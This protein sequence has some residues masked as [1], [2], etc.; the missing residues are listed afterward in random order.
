MGELISGISRKKSEREDNE[1]LATKL[2]FDYAYGQIILDENTRHLCIFTVMGG[3][4]TGFYHFLK[5]FYDLAGI[6]TIFQER[7]D[8]TLEYKHPS[9]LDDIIIVT[10]GDVEKHEAEVIE[11][12]KKLENAGYGLNP[13]TC[14]L[15]KRKRE[16]I[17]HTID[18]QKRRPLQDKLEAIKKIN[19]SK[20]EKE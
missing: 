18:Q 12:M 2:D 5:R 7:I 8:K 11:I 4:F 16:L 17:G 1:I 14:E 6:P 3:E 10:K 19:T 13:K 9:W 20:N 15:F